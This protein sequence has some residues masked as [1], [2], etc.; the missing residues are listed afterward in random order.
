MNDP[1]A[2]LREEGDPLVLDGAVSVREQHPGE[3]TD[4]ALPDRSY[5][6]SGVSKRPSRFSI[7]AVVSP[8]PGHAITTT[9]DARILEVRAWLERAQLNAEILDVQRPGRALAV[10]YLVESYN[11]EQGNSNAERLTLELKSMRLAST[12][13]VT[14]ERRVRERLPTEEAAPGQAVEVEGGRRGFKSITAGGLDAA[15]GLFGGGS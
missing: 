2:L 8:T 1:V 9:G 15:T 10:G 6:T 12:E 13:S 14:I 7:D 11:L 3:V 5:A 4:H